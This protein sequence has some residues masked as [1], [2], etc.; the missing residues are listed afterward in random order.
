MFLSQSDSFSGM[1]KEAHNTDAAS[2]E[3][4]D[5]VDLEVQRLLSVYD[6]V[7]DEDSSNRWAHFTKF[8]DEL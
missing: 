1:S 8:T 4:V 2:E 7:K 6:V 5:D 3:V